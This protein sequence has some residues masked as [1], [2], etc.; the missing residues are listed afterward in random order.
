MRVTFKICLRGVRVY[1]R[2]KLV[3]PQMSLGIGFVDAVNNIPSCARAIILEANPLH[4][5]TGTGADRVHPLQIEGG[6]VFRV[7]TAVRYPSSRGFFAWQFCWNV[8]SAVLV[9][10]PSNPEAD[11]VA[12]P[13]NQTTAKARRILL[14]HFPCA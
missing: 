3:D 12:L 2:R 11:A 4:F 14:W 13:Q 7:F 1:I 8:T 9:R 6:L 10:N 5:D